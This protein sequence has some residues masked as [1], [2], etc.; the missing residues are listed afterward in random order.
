MIKLYKFSPIQTKEELFEAIN[1]IATK[2]TELCKKITGETYPIE[3][4]TVFS[5]YPNEFEL[6]KQ[7]AFQIG[8]KDS[9]VNGPYV[10]LRES[11]Q[12]PN[13]KLNQL[14]I[15]QPD[16]YRM[17]V[18]CNDFVVPDY[19]AFKTKYLSS[20]L[21]NLRLIQRPEYHMIEFFDPDFDVLAYV[22]SN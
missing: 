5:H 17:Q 11:V 19:E 22:L 6:L 10:K 20:K 14:R 4:L 16:P 7:I 9:E 2:S 8:D 1:Y 12:L 21:N 3:P 18:G 13:N 15:R